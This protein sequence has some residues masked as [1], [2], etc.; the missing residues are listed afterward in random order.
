MKQHLK[1][2]GPVTQVQIPMH[3]SALTV[4][5]PQ[6][7]SIDIRREHGSSREV[8]GVY[9]FNCPGHPAADQRLLTSKMRREADVIWLA[10]LRQDRFCLT[11]YYNWQSLHREWPLCLPVSD[12]FLI[13]FSSGWHDTSYSDEIP[14]F[15]NLRT[16]GRIFF[17]E[18]LS[19]A[20]EHEAPECAGF[21]C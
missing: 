7:F 1:S 16:V 15:A 14:F 17:V 5:V 20:S 4:D 12:V 2:K 6:E 13:A 3:I 19:S 21:R 9:R 11:E 18:L 8:G 10:N